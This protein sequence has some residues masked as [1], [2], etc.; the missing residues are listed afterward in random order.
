M[1]WG[2]D[3]EVF[4]QIKPTNWGTR[5]RNWHDTMQSIFLRKSSEALIF[6]DVSDFAEGGSSDKRLVTWLQTLA[7]IFTVCLTKQTFAFKWNN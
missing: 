2:L 3:S 6:I 5:E 7:Q 4:R 1:D